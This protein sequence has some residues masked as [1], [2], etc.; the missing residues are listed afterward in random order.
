MHLKLSASAIEIAAAAYLLLVMPWSADVCR[1]AS[2]SLNTPL[3]LPACHLGA[4]FP[5]S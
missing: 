3:A 4:A 1:V 2:E 5:V